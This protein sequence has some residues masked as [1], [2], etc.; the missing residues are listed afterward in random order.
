MSQDYCHRY[1]KI[2]WKY[3]AEKRRVIMFRLRCWQWDCSYCAVEN[4][5]AWRN[6]LNDQ[7]PRISGQWW[8]MT[9]TATNRARGRIESYKQLQSGI[10]L[11]I[12]RFRR[13]FG[14][15]SYVRVFEKH[16]SSDALHAHFIVSGISDYVSIQRQKNGKDRYTATNFRAGKRGF[17]AVRT[18][19]KKTAQ[20][21]GMGYMADVKP[22]TQKTATRYVTEYLTKTGQSID[23]RGL[24]HVATTRDIKSPR[25][26]DAKDKTL[27]IGY[28]IGRG[29]MLPSFSLLDRDTGELIPDSYWQEH[30]FYPPES[31]HGS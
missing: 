5:K 14:K 7:L 29:S 16:P 31:D 6:A 27:Y 17:W 2:G 9:L 19:A 26:R 3:D 25:K 20:A 10:D 28:R 12:K 15:I 30:Q 1:A 24:R 13:A 4:R 8:L 23:I 18:F 21:C 11:L 22:I